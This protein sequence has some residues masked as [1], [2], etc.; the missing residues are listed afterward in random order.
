MSD[1]SALRQTV[2]T[3][4]GLGRPER[5]W[6]AAAELWSEGGHRQRH[7]AGRLLRHLAPRIPAGAWTTRRQRLAETVGVPSTPA[8]R[9]AGVVAFPVVG[10]GGD[11]FLQVAVRVRSTPSDSLPSAIDDDTELALRE[12]L[13][14]AR[15]WLGEH[16]HF[17][18]HVSSPLTWG[19]ASVGLATG[20]A[21]VSAA[22]SRALDPCLSATGRLRADGG[23]R[24]V[25]AMPEKLRLRFEARPR[26]RLLVAMSDRV[27]AQP[28]VT[29]VRTLD[30]ALERVGFDSETDPY[31]RLDAIRR[32][33]REGDWVDAAQA[34]EALWAHPDLGED[35]RLELLA[36]LLTA[37]NH[38]ADRDRFLRLHGRL[39]G[40][41]EFSTGSLEHARCIS[42]I[43]VQAVDQL[44]L[45]GVQR[46]LSLARH[47]RWP[48]VARVHVRGSQSLAATLRGEHLLALELRE[49]NL[50]EAGTAERARCWGDLAD[51]LLRAGEVDRA[52]TATERGLECASV[53]VR[54]G[55]QE[56]TRAYL[57]LHR[58][59][60]LA[61]AGFVDEALALTRSV[62]RAPGP[63]PALRA[64]LLAAELEADLPG[65]GRAEAELLGNVPRPPFLAVLLLRSR[66]RL[67]DEDARIRLLEEPAFR[68]LDL[69]EASRRL[70]Y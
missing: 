51:A 32:K 45:E 28:A 15:A 35:D 33:D 70:P 23:I 34:A 14:A 58:A 67:G 8:P 55:Y 59:R 62:S 7:E 38:T 42:A 6:D 54:P 36:V 50:D 63:D 44:N 19:G 26:G 37:A 47:E 57:E 43:L 30:H 2:R 65:V 17:E 27:E 13:S 11:R 60:A 4:L 39:R 41:V 9:E 22:R 18:V 66:A 25:G 56:R 10:A 12:A 16:V 40:L 21:A 53:R 69:D 61:A 31:P 46:A 5:A 68:G 1:I 20:L 52:C 24:P 64:R 29:G 49:K 48:R 3:A